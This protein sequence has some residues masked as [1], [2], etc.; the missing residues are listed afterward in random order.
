MKRFLFTGRG[1]RASGENLRITTM[2]KCITAVGSEMTYKDLLT[3]E[4]TRIAQDDRVRFIGYNTACG[5]RFNGTLVNVPKDRCIEMPV[6]ENLI[7]GVAMGMALEG[8][9]PIVCFERMDF[10]LACADA[11]INHLDK[12]PRLSGEQFFFPLIIRTCVGDNAPLHAGPQHTGDYTDLFAKNTRIE[13]VWIGD[14]RDIQS[15]YKPIPTSVYGPKIMVEY[16]EL[17]DCKLRRTY[18]RRRS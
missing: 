10:L 16:K 4:M 14:V 15:A 5:H 18:G 6:A 8:F 1:L 13:V 17:Y 12:L 7:M 2:G 9:I 3:H 11:I